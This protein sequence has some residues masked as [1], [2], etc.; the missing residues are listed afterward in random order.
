M[1]ST[2]YLVPVP[3]TVPV[4]V[5]LSDTPCYTCS[6]VQNTME[7][8]AKLLIYRDLASGRLKLHEVLSRASPLSLPV[9]PLST[10]STLYSFIAYRYQKWIKYEAGCDVR[11]I[12]DATEDLGIDDCSTLTQTHPS[13]PTADCLS[14]WW[15]DWWRF[16]SGICNSSTVPVA[17][18]DVLANSKPR[19]GVLLLVILSYIGVVWTNEKGS[20]KIKVVTVTVLK[21]AVNKCMVKLVWSWKFVSKLNMIV[22]VFSYQGIRDEP[23]SK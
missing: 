8:K 18:D 13:L 16:W 7:N 4:G 15:F 6:T 1:Y 14:G 2:L 20:Y 11:I 12:I 5:A 23:G 21:L 10:T 9:H 22:V 17:S 3:G 19:K